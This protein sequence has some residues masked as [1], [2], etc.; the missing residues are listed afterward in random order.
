MSPETSATHG[1]IIHLR[2]QHQGSY[3]K[4]PAKSCSRTSFLSTHPPDSHT[5]YTLT[6]VGH[7]TNATDT[8]RTPRAPQQASRHITARSTRRTDS[9]I[10]ARRQD[11]TG[12]NEGSMTRA[13]S[14]KHTGTTQLFTRHSYIQCTLTHF[15]THAPQ[16]SNL[17]HVRRHKRS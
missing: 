4:K 16:M 7:P 9:G 10:A 1:N 2:H 14:R 11:K 17:I 5:T 15:T 12:G 3:M 8:A 6:R 13:A